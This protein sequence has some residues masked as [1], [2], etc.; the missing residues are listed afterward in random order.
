MAAVQRSRSCNLHVVV[1]YRRIA[2]TTAC[3]VYGS[4]VVVAAL[5]LGQIVPGIRDQA[6]ACCG[7]LHM[8]SDPQPDDVRAMITPM[9]YR[10]RSRAPCISTIAAVVGKDSS[11]CWLG[12]AQALRASPW[13]ILV[14]TASA[15]PEDHVRRL[16]GL[17]RGFYRELLPLQIIHPLTLPLRR[18]MS[19][20][21][22]RRQRSRASRAAR[23]WTRAA[24][25]RSSATCTRTRAGSGP[26]SRPAHPPASMRR[27]SCETR[28]KS[29]LAPIRATW[30]A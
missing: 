2:I 23:S 22:S 21:R 8:R 11:L 18:L 20:R 17:L 4:A 3:R 10:V 6:A 30:I 14:S 29:K 1:L 13:R 27:S 28:A 25:R 9:L 5:V 15:I 24:T 12:A 7:A 16:P 19:S 26:R